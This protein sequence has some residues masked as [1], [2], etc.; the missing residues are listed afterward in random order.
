LFVRDGVNSGCGAGQAE[1]LFRRLH[2]QRNLPNS[3]DGR[4]RRTDEGLKQTPAEEETVDRRCYLSIIMMAGRM[5]A[6]TKTTAAV[7]MSD[8]SIP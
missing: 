8:C 5:P 6:K 4:G 2:Q 1:E 7:R 3:W